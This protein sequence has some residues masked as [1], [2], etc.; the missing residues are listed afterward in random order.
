MSC[1]K[2]LSKNQKITLL[3]V[4]VAAISGIAVPVILNL[5]GKKVE[6][7]PTTEKSTST[8]N[9]GSITGDGTVIGDNAKVTVVKSQ[10]VDPNLLDRLMNTSQTLGQVEQTLR[11][12]ELEKEQLK[13]Q[14][15]KAIERANNILAIGNRPDAEKALAAARES[16][17]L[18]SLLE[19]L[20][21]DRE[22]HKEALI[23]R[24]RE[25]AAVAYL[26]GDIEIAL[27]AI[28]TILKESPEDLSSLSQKGRIYVLRGLLKEAESNY[29]R[30]LELA[31][32]TG[33][34]Q[35][36]AVA[37]SGLGGIYLIRG[38]L[39]KAEEMLKKSLEIVEKLGSKEDM[40]RVY[41]NLGSVYLAR[42]DLDRAVEMYLNSLKI[43]EELGS[44]VGMATDYGNLGI[45]Y[46]K[47]G[48]MDKAEELYKKALDIDMKLS[49]LEGMARHYSN[50]ATIYETRGDLDK[51]REY[52]EKALELFKKIGMSHMVEKVQKWIDDIEK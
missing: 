48:D 25:I 18:S 2:G 42:G 12:T 47:R 27:E 22:E 32:Q 36:Q 41:N 46:H 40:S 13:E 23:Q 35:D 45:V 34:N 1:L 37:L 49:H 4:L 51:A 8:V 9:V 38:D 7:P 19:L 5:T 28:D 50:L 30:V 44:K 6:S 24:N 14:L 17:D 11:Q 10:S 20:L 43:D 52:W 26:R 39:V 29:S 21:K 16:G 31:T 3:G 33:N 15:A